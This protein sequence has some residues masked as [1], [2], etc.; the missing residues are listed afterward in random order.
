LSSGNI[1]I[2]VDAVQTAAHSH[3]FLSVTKS[4]HTAI[5]ETRGN[6]DCHIILRGGKDPNYDP[7]SVGSAITALEKMS[8]PTRVMIDCSHANSGKDYRK[9]KVA[10]TSVADQIRRGSENILGIMLESNLVEGK[11]DFSTSKAMT[12]GQSITDGCVGLEETAE[13]LEML[14]NV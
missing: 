6:P 10:A 4:G 5:V 11:Q 13:I 8:L 3:H 9:Q 2:A 14:A 12:Y 7:A 1:Q